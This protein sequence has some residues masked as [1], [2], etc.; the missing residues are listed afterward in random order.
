MTQPTA[1]GTL[2]VQ[3]RGPTGAEGDMEESAG[4]PNDRMIEV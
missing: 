3:V 4:L 1:S 2:R